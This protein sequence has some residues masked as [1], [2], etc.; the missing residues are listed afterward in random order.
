[1]LKNGINIKGLIFSL[2]KLLHKKFY[3]YVK[4]LNKYINPLSIIVI[5]IFGIMLIYI[6]NY[7]KKYNH[8]DWWNWKKR[9]MY[10][11]I[12]FVLVLVLIKL[13]IKGVI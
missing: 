5:C 12:N 13:L 10:K 3:F 9:A 2:K 11:S 1:M 6:R 4:I 7:I 8:S